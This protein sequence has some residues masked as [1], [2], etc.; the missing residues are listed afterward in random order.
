MYEKSDT[1]V[2]RYK[3]KF[4][5]N[6]IIAA[7]IIIGITIIGIG[8]VFDGL[9]KTI[10]FCREL[11]NSVTTNQNPQIPSKPLENNTISPKIVLEPEIHR[12]LYKDEKLENLQK[13]PILDKNL[14]VGLYYASF[15]LGGVNKEAL[16]IAARSEKA[17]PL[18]KSVIPFNNPR[19]SK[20]EDDIILIDNIGSSPYI[21]LEYKKHYYSIQVNSQMWSVS[22]AL[23][24]NFSMDEIETPT[25]NLTEF[26]QIPFKE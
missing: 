8:S 23:Y 24:I 2:D 12:S 9:T 17:E 26:D 4:F 7:L 1:R 5:N 21:E 18:T 13:Y 11:F 19:F 3:N 25:M 10:N 20:Y 6:K 15:M 14:Y 16:K 22:D